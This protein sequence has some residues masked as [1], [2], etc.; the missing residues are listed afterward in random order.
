MTRPRPPGLGPAVE[1]CPSS[2]WSRI[3]S[4]VKAEDLWQI[5]G[6]QVEKHLNT[7]PLWKVFAV[8]YFEGLMHGAAVA[9]EQS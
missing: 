2:A 3:P 9:R 4:G 7:L 6:P 8:V 1:I 5:V